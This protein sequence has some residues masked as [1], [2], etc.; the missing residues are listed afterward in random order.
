VV[1]LR[2][3]L[4]FNLGMAALFALL[5]AGTYLVP[6]SR[7]RQVTYLPSF[8]APSRQMV[9]ESDD[10]ESVR[11]K[12]LYYFDLAKGLKVRQYEN[13]EDHVATLRIVSYLSALALTLSAALA[14]LFGRVRGTGGPG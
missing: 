7:A 12:A 10:M 3:L 14:C 11:T 6:D 1:T 13:D 4:L 5:A 9:A 8:D 2:T